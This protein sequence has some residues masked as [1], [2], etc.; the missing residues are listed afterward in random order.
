[1]EVFNADD[2]GYLFAEVHDD[3][4]DGFMESCFPVFRADV[5]NCGILDGI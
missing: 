5:F 3:K 2:C 4:P 1:M